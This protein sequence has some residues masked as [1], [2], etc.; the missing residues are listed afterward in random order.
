M[1][2]L[3]FFLLLAG[4]AVLGSCSF[5]PEYE[6]P[7]FP[8]SS[9]WENPD[10]AVP[11]SS[12]E[13]T[14]LPEDSSETSPA[15]AAEEPSSSES[16]EAPP[17]Q[18]EQNPAD[19]E[20][21]SLSEL[22]QEE[23][24][25]S[26]G[27]EPLLS[28]EAPPVAS[29]THW[30]AFF[31]QP[32]LQEIISVALAHNRDLRLAALNIEEARALYRISRAELIPGLDAGGQAH[33]RSDSDESNPQGKAETTESYSANIA[34]PYYEI[35][36]FGKIRSQNLAATRTYLATREAKRTL[37]ISLIAEVAN[38]YL[39]LLADQKLLLL[40]Q[41][42]LIA[43]QHT[44]DLLSKSRK[45]GVATQLDV[46]RATTAVE[47]AQVSLFQYQQNVQKDRNA[48][49][50]LM[51]IQQDSFS[52]PQ[53]SLDELTFMDDLAT[54]LRS[55]V[56]LARPDIRQAEYTLLSRN[57]DI[58]AARAA[59][60]PS[61]TITGDF[62][63]AS[64]SLGALF[65]GGASGAWNFIPKISI[66]IF[67]GGRHQAN[68]EASKIQKEMAAVKYEQ[69]IQNAFREVADE[70]AAR[71]A[72]VRQ[73]EAQARLVKAAGQA[74]SISLARYKAGI[75]SFLSVLDA[76]RE[77]YAYQQLQIQIEQQ[78]LTNLVNLYKV[79]GGG[80]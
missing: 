2:K 23:P 20:E 51:G 48:L 63:F 5:I 29:Q 42:T 76:Q 27:D 64:D 8:A 38:A 11:E 1:K 15:T 34:L 17:P 30:K 75:D 40:A 49:V 19:T 39:Q 12:C 68:L 59:F 35:D 56:L 77:L 37:Q 22:P 13:E 71:R 24:E 53:A 80:A 45:N 73:L 58:G 21:A 41:Q 62:G 9:S 61:V 6:R 16:S 50:L 74:Y 66:P 10:S 46:A 57:A 67:H 4:V 70:L 18:E 72:L 78:Y 14:P 3:P 26:A 55:E 65:T 32:E 25:P 69:A 43:Q 28:E 33:Y 47:T 52:M 79:L 31:H 7:E 44:R 60:F 36:F 54:G